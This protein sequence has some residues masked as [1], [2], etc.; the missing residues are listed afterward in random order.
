MQRSEQSTNQVSNPSGVPGTAS[1]TPAPSPNGATQGSSAATPAA[2]PLL[3]KTV[4]PVYPQAAQPGQTL[5]EES[6][7]YA[8][9]KH[10]LHST[11]G[12]GRLRRIT[13]AILVNDRLSTEGDGRLRH[14]VWRSRSPDEM[15]RMEDLAEASIGFDSKRGD[16]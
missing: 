16:R 9:S 6:G 14:S 1:N 13:A 2:P 8:V 10:T 3:Q 11:A 12:P 4:T 7:T 5:K 15:H